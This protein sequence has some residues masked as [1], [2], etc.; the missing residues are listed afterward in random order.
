[1]G[2]TITPDFSE[3]VDL[4]PVPPGSYKVR[5]TDAKAKVS[6]TGNPLVEWTL[7][8]FG[9]NNASLNNRNVWHTTST[10]GRGAGFLKQFL[11]VATGEE[12]TGSFNTDAIMGRELQA[13]VEEGRTAT[14]EPSGFPKVKAVAKLSS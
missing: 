6:Q 3:S 9:D 4:T 10:T 1:M 12:P 8:I 5:V 7:T 2:I 11:R 14:G 13:I